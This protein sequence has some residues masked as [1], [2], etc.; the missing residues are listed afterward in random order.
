VPEVEAHW[1]RVPGGPWG[2]TVEQSVFDRAWTR[3]SQED[4]RIIL[5]LLAEYGSIT[6]VPDGPSGGPKPSPLEGE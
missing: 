1:A 4:L 5:E 3:R 6:I 2:K